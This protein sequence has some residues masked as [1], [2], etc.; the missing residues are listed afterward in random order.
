MI[1]WRDNTLAIRLASDGLHRQVTLAVCG[2][3]CYKAFAW[4]VKGWS[5]LVKSGIGFCWFGKV[6]TVFCFCW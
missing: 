4:F 6:R 2:G 5:D 1:K 3:F